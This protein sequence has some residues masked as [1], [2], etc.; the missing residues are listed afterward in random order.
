MLEYQKA[1]QGEVSDFVSHFPSLGPAGAVNQVPRALPS[2]SSA[3]LT[4]SCGHLFPTAGMPLPLPLFSRAAQVGWVSSTCHHSPSISLHKT[5]T[6]L[7]SAR[8]LTCLY[9]HFLHLLKNFSLPVMI[10]WRL[11][12]CFLPYTIFQSE[13]SIK[14]ADLQGDHTNNAVIQ[15]CC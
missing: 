5:C 9:R 2:A 14:L 6:D 10:V 7:A 3:Q 8:L 4:P 1:L 11:Q 15:L 12:V 13:F